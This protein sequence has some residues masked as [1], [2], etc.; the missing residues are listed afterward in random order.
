MSRQE[1]VDLAEVVTES[2]GIT[3]ELLVAGRLTELAVNESRKLPE[4]TNRQILEEATQI[5]LERNY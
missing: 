4:S 2:G 1:C 5:L 3:G